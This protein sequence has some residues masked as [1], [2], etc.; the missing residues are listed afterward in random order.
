MLRWFLYVQTCDLAVALIPVEL[1]GDWTDDR[2]VTD[3]DDADEAHGDAL[4]VA[5]VDAGGPAESHPEALLPRLHRL[6]LPDHRHLQCTVTA[7]LL[8]VKALEAHEAL[9]FPTVLNRNF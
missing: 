6:Q 7:K 5:G 8:S 9:Q 1:I 3:V 4:V 2:P